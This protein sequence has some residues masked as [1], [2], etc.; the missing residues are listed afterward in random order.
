[1]PNFY[2]GGGSGTWSA[3]DT[4]HW[5]SDPALTTLAGAVPS[6]S[7]N[8]YFTQTITYIVT[9]TGNIYCNNLFIT[10]GKITFTSTGTLNISGSFSN[11]SAQVHTVTITLIS[12][13]STSAGNTIS[14]NGNTIDTAITFNGVGGSWS[15][16]GALTISSTR[17]LTLLAGTLNLNTYTLSCGIFDSATTTNVRSINFNSGIIT[18]SSTSWNVA[19]TN[20]TYSGTG[21]INFTY[22][23]IKTFTGGSMVYPV[24]LNH[25]GSGSL[26]I[27]GS[28]TFDTL[29]TNTLTAIST[30]LFTAGS[31]TTV[32]NFTLKGTSS[33]SFTINSTVSGSA[34]TINKAG[35]GIIYA[36]R[37]QIAN[38]TATPI[39]TW[40]A[41]SSCGNIGNNTNWNF[42]FVRY[43]V[44]G[45]GTWDD[46]STTNWAITSGGSSGAPPPG[47]RD[48][49]F[50]DQNSTY[51]V[52]VASG[53]SKYCQDL[54]VSSGT[55]TF[56]SSSTI[57]VTGSI[58][59]KS[60]TVWGASGPTLFFLQSS[61]S[62]PTTRTI[63]TNGVQL[64]NIN[65]S[66][67]ILDGVH[68]PTF[69]LSDNLSL[70]GAITVYAGI[71]DTG[72]YTVTCLYLGLMNTSPP[73]AAK[74]I[75]LNAS[76]VNF[77]SNSGLYQFGTATNYTFNAGTSTINFREKI[78]SGANLTYYDVNISTPNTGGYAIWE[79]N[80]Y[81]NLT[82]T[83]GTTGELYTVD[84][85]G[86]Q[87]INGTLSST[88]ASIINRLMFRSDTY[89][90]S[91]TLTVGTLSTP[92]SDFRYITIA[93]TATNTLVTNGGDC[94]GNSGIQ[95]PSTKTVYWNL[96]GTQNWYST[97]WCTSG[98]GGATFNA[99]NINN[100]PLAQ[101]TAIINNNSSGTS[102]N[103]LANPTAANRSYN[104]PNLDTSSRT[105]AIS[106]AFGSSGGQ[107]IV[108]GNFKLGTGVT[109]SP[110]FM[111]ITFS[112][113][114]LTHNLLNNTKLNNKN[115]YFRV[116]CPGGTVNLLDA[117]TTLSAV[118]LSAGTLNLNG[119]NLSAS[120]F[121]DTLYTGAASPF[122]RTLNFGTNAT[123]TLSA[124]SGTY[125][126]H[127]T[128]GSGGFLNIGG[129][130]TISITGAGGSRSFVSP[131]CLNLSSITL[132]NASTGI[133]ILSFGNGATVSFY[134]FSNT[135]TPANFTFQGSGMTIN[136][137]NFT[138]KGVS[139]GL[140]TI[141]NATTTT[142]LSKTSG[143]VAGD[144]LSISNSIATGGAAWYAGSHS[145]N[146]TPLT[147]SGWIWG[148][149]TTNNFLPFLINH[150]S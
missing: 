33:Y 59:L 97:G 32:T 79:S 70:V 87:T 41:V 82:I 65:M 43:W 61:T 62:Y 88:S 35:G 11:T 24:T 5:Y 54:T 78:N 116:E 47:S 132:N 92:N 15:L 91:R 42:I 135:V 39:N 46:T 134:D 94:T 93:G 141:T 107:A 25:S 17:T 56:S 14:T 19:S 101:D 45:T 71:F 3:A 18:I 77:T 136:L 23:G 143:V 103:M 21:T 110:S 95:F 118:Y 50:F 6:S 133:V 8:V 120:N 90:T 75:N 149:L 63:K 58:D 123:L 37:L 81:N 29:G 111:F 53:F 27:V 106:L 20:L 69:L 83:A 52:T 112:G 109:I 57:F 98:D 13:N 105:S 12:F 48:D 89:G 67:S 119:Y 148:D 124:I 36:E 137:S 40:Y 146:V 84:F 51:T 130:G 85:Y 16:S 121:D 125:A 31:T 104:L 127:S 1:M 140:V 60:T 144:Y 100:F 99:P 113:A 96:S 22:I 66:D 131:G 114:G 117:L 147:N 72:S 128:L 44:G 80:T 73:V 139:G 9:C 10:N 150:P 28:N 108:Y 145:V 129:T 30:L 142:T 138:A 7:D 115:L 76:T 74:T 68:I 4:T 2:W 55:V 122:S 64:K 86:N 102:I 49:I 38:S 34:F 126:W 26:T